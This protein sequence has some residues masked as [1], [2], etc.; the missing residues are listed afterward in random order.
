MVDKH[1]KL[2]ISLKKKKKNKSETTIER[3]LNFRFEFRM[4]N[5]NQ[6]SFRQLL[7]IID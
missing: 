5:S 3:T 1:Q 4:V 7:S 6:R 2:I